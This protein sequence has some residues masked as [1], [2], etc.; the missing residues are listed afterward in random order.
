MKARDL[1]AE[2]GERFARDVAEH[3]LTVLHDDG[4][5]R[6]LRFK[7]PDS[8]FYWFD[9]VTWPG[10]LA[11]N[12]DMGTFT[13]SRLTD[14]F[15]FFR[16]ESG[17]NMARIN[18]QYWAEKVKGGT[19][20]SEFSEAL[21]RDAVIEDFT[22]AVKNG[23]VPAGLGKAV[24]EEIFEAYDISFESEA[25][26]AVAEFEYEYPDGTHQHGSPKYSQ[27]RFEGA[28]EWSLHTWSH[29][30]LWCCNAIQWGI[31][32]YDR[33]PVAAPVAVSA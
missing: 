17:W 26:R 29:H 14:M 4:L 24:R 10:M 8:S 20:T 25:M 27:W 32:Q 19:P 13:F 9:L 1:L 28:Y 33:R 21:F 6:H 2:S 5:Y 31:E 15:E 7:R 11:I 23:G 30:Y 3:Q 12:G 18:P 22:A 16:Q